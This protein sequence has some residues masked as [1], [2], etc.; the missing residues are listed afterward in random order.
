MG[1]FEKLKELKADLKFI[2]RPGRKQANEREQALL[3]RVSI[4]GKQRELIKIQSINKD[5][6]TLQN[7]ETNIKK[8]K[9]KNTRLKHPNLFKALNSVKKNMKVSLK[10]MKQGNN[11]VSN[12]NNPYN[13]NGNNNNSIFTQGTGTD[14]IFTKGGG[15]N[16]IYHGGKK[17]R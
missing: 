14:N 3:N 9:K 2:T 15:Y 17:K 4:K 10:K 12:P 16:P 11:M 6:E 5:M 13:F 8:A 1:I 7:L